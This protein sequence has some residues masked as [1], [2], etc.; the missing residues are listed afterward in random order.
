MFYYINGQAEIIE[1]NLVVLDVN[2]VGYAVSTSLNTSSGV[3]KGEMTKLYTYMNVKEDTFEI[4]GFASMEELGFFKQLISISGVGVKAAVSILSVASPSKLALA[5]I[6]GDEKLITQANG[7][8]KKIAQRVILELRD[9]IAKS[10][11][12]FHSEGISL[13]VKGKEQAS[14]FDDALSALEVL[15]YPKTVI[16]QVLTGEDIEGKD[17]EDII[18]TALKKLM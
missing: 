12:T 9:K 18:R 7:I 2:G 16:M 14:D 15:G 3:K 11:S 6:S 1:P 17:T 8:G 4:Y 10:Q 5:I 13:P